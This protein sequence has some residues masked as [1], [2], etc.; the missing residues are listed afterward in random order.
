MSN[1]NIRKKI[2]FIYLYIFI[3]SCVTEI[4]EPLTSEINIVD[5]N[6]DYDQYDN[7]VHE[8]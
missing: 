3:F 5:F 6:V 7:Q 8:C 2:N 1:S 4:Q